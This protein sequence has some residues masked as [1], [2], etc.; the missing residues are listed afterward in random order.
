MKAKTLL[1]TFACLAAAAPAFAGQ[2]IHG[3]NTEMG[4]T[5]H[6][7]H[8][9]QGL[10]RE[11]VRAELMAAKAHPS[12]AQLRVGASPTSFQSKLSRAE[13]E[14]ELLRAQM[15]PTWNARRVGAP[16]SMD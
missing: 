6:P 10:T 8:A 7:D 5:V 14:A 1:A 13:V 11:Q 4:Y 9:S 15:H 2:V 12:W 16:V 3:A